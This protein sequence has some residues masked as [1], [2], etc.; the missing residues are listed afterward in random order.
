MFPVN[1]NTVDYFPVY[2]CLPWRHHVITTWRICVNQIV[3]SNNRHSIGIGLHPY[4][5]HHRWYTKLCNSYLSLHPNSSLYHKKWGQLSGG[6][7]KMSDGKNDK[8][9][10]TN[11]GKHMPKSKLKWQ[12]QIMPQLRSAYKVC[13]HQTYGKHDVL[14]QQIHS[15]LPFRT[16]ICMYL[17]P[18]EFSTK[19]EWRNI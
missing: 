6:L 16:A 7:Q 12:Y 13:Q 8:L 9:F 10:K 17:P 19:T 15:K 14:K 1:C 18:S 3:D 2:S 11:S 4:H 5:L